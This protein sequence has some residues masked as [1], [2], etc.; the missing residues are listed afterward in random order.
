MNEAIDRS[1]PGARER[2]LFCSYHLRNSG[3]KT[4]HEDLARD[5]P[6]GDG[7]GVGVDRGRVRQILKRAENRLIG[8][9]LR[10]PGNELYLMIDQEMLNSM[11][12]EHIILDP[13]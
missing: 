8:Y 9:V 4:T 3:K 11:G 10:N 6:R 7:T 1:I 13:N 2:Q 5:L 12:F